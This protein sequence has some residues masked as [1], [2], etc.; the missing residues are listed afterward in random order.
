[1]RAS[2]QLKFAEEDALIS[3][4]LEI[5]GAREI[6]RDLMTNTELP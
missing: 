1:M 2:R 6:D 4:R 3:T 5:A